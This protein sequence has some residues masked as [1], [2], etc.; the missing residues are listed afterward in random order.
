MQKLIALKNHIE[1][2]GLFNPER[3]IEYAEEGTAH[4]SFSTSGP[5]L[6]LCRH[7]YTGVIELWGASG[8]LGHLLAMVL[9]WLDANGGDEDAL[10]SWSGEPVDR[11]RA[12]ITLRLTLEEDAR[13]VPKGAYA[14]KDVLTF[15]GT[16]WRPGEA[17]ADK[18]TTLEGDG[19]VIQP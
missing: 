1:A 14:G 9:T 13:Y 4:T 3:V 15:E 8:S 2:S 11:A 16:E 18:A 5:D 17:V 7:A 6:L 12:D 10:S 19:V